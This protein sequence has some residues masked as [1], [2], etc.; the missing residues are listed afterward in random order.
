MASRMSRRLSATGVSPRASARRAAASSTGSLMAA[1]FKLAGQ[2][3][4]AAGRPVVTRPDHRLAAAERYA[5]ACAKGLENVIWRPNGERNVD[6]VQH[7]S[8]QCLRMNGDQQGAAQRLR[9]TDVRLAPRGG[10]Q[11]VRFVDDQ[12]VWTPSLRSQLLH[13]RQQFGEKGGPL[14]YAQ[15]QQV[16]DHALGGILKDADY[17]A[18]AW[19]AVWS[20]DGN[21]DLQVVIVTFGINDAELVAV[22][23]E[24]LQNSSGE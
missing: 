16:D 17:L 4:K 7:V 22:L 11:V 20:A 5:A 14:L 18:D 21:G 2:D 9:K 3:S 23:M 1:L 8:G 15:G 12:P 24:P 19:G 6:L 10:K 13:V